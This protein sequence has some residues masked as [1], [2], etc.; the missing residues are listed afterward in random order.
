MT[1]DESFLE[2]YRRCIAIY[3]GGDD[4]FHS[5]YNAADLDFLASIGYKPRELFDFVE[6]F[7]DEG[8][9]SESAAL[10]IAAVR[11]DYFQVVQGGKPS[12]REVTKSDLPGF[13]EEVGGIAY[14]PR[15]LTKARAK[16]AGELH[17]DVMF[18]CGGDRK[19]L[20]EQGD[21]S[22]ADFLRRVWA[23][24]GDDQK[25]VDWLKGSTH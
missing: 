10:L 24:D 25:I 21:L 13:G 20:R 16:L 3:Q 11:R 15:I 4:D 7:V 22:A 12:E 1:W 6:D 8:V 9:P 18:S 19:F 2:L 14:L 5:Y 17:P 23:S